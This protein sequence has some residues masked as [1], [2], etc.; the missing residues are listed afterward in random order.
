MAN[1]QPKKMES[2]AEGN[3]ASLGFEEKLWPS[4]DNLRHS[5]DATENRHVFL[6]LI[7]PK[8]IYDDFQA[9]RVELGALT[10]DPKSDYFTGGEADWTN[11]PIEDKVERA[12]RNVIW[13]PPEARWKQHPAQAKRPDIA[14]LIDDGM[15]AI[16]RDNPRLKNVLPGGYT[17]RDMPAERLSALMDL[18]FGIGLGE[19]ESRAKDIPGRF[20]GI[21]SSSS[22]PPSL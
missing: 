21:S 16:E 22:P 8:S 6:G 14:R 18:I 1:K 7:F 3:V 19:K 13:V 9:R 15:Y 5:I 2:K 4:A 12:S 11:Q 10:A 17:R 20:M